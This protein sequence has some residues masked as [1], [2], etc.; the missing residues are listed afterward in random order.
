MR[1]LLAVL[2]PLLVLAACGGD[3]VADG[4]AATVVDSEDTPVEE[5]AEEDLTEAVDGDEDVPETTV[6]DGATAADGPD[7]GAGQDEG[8]GDAVLATEL[9]GAGP[10][11]G[12]GHPSATGRFEAE[13]VDG[14]LCVDMVLQDLDSAVIEAHVHS[15]R[16]GEE[17]PVIVDIGLPSSTS[18]GTSTWTDVCT[19]V[20][21]DVI[22]DL[23]AAPELAYVDVH[24]GSHPD[25]AVRGQLG[26]ISIFDR[27]LD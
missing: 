5:D 17:G 11:P 22:E 12:P 23:A 2:V 16:A 14:T 18:D 1:R 19:G 24:S 3:D 4:P 10:A 13:L 25:G 15:G 8:L 21:D 6:P 27:T 7:S 9:D 20:A 26:V